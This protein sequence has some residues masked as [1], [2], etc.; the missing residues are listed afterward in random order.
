MGRAI[1]PPSGPPACD[2]MDA[3]EA[4]SGQS[5]AS[6]TKC[7]LRGPCAWEDVHARSN[8]SPSTLGS[9]SSLAREC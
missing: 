5:D 4:W 9:A 1:T 8:P 6:E 3:S 2:T 7:V